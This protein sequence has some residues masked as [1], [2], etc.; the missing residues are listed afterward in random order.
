MYVLNI[1][2]YAYVVPFVEE[3]EKNFLKT[4]Y[5]SRTMTKKY[6]MEVNK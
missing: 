1:D 6:I 3:R 2:K 4:I 5:P